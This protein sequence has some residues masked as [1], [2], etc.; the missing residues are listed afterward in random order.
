MLAILNAGQTGV[1]PGYTLLN[2]DKTVY[3]AALGT[4]AIRSPAPLGDT[5]L[6]DLREK[7]AAFWR[8]R[9]ASSSVRADLETIRDG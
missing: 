8:A 1:T 5:D 7:L 4:I 3:E 6:A 9:F 2:S